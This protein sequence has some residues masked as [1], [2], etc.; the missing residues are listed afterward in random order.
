[1]AYTGSKQDDISC[2]TFVKGSRT[3]VCGK[4]RYHSKKDRKG[5]LVARKRWLYLPLIPRLRSLFNSD[6]AEDL[7]T[8]RASFHGEMRKNIGV[9]EDVFDRDLYRNVHR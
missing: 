6:L 8:Y 9:R 1:M 4:P 5:Q 2:S 3:K 7:T